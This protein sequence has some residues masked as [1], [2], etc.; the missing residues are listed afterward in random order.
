MQKTKRTAN[1][2][3]QVRTGLEGPKHDL[4]SYEEITYVKGGVSATYHSGLGDWIQVNTPTKKLKF[5]DRPQGR[6]ED[7]VGVS[8]KVLEKALHRPKKCCNKPKTQ[9][10]AGYPG[11][12]LLVCLNCRKVIDGTFNESAII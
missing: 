8:L 4:Y 10:R 1:G 11:E 3:V 7:F 9:W 12:E 6:F 2:Y 5:F